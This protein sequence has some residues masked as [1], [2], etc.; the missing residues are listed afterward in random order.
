MKFTNTLVDVLKNFST[1]NQSILFK[2]GKIVSTVS[3]LKTILA[4]AIV[5]VEI[6]KEFAIYDLH[7]FLAVVSL[8]PNS[9]VSFTEHQIILSSNR[10][11]IKYTFAHPSTITASQYN[12]INLEDKDVITSFNLPYNEIL[13]LSKISAVWKSDT[14]SISG[15]DGIVTIKAGNLKDQSSSAYLF[16][17]G[18]VQKPFNQRF[19]MNIKV[20]SLRLLNK[21]YIVTIPN[22]KLVQFSDVDQSVTYWLAVDQ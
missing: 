6:E 2:P 3:P 15:D 17:V 14:I 9:E 13:N 7:E 18:D 10:K 11:K 5:D 12:T 1:I 16:E 20:E 19:S 22:K 4:N 21:N 8:M